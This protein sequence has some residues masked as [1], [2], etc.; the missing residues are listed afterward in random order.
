MY[1]AQTVIVGGFGR[2]RAAIDKIE[3]LHPRH[4]VC[5]HQNNQLDDD[6][7][8]TIAET[9]QY[10]DDAE[11]LLQTHETALDLFNAKLER[12]PN[13][14][15]GT[16]LWAGVQTLYGGRE[17]PEENIRRIIVRSWLCRRAGPSARRA[18]A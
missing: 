14:L 15:G 12:Y 13:H 5:G 7:R 18:Q 6:A 16:L 2:W 1:L 11:E 10:L 17:H 3:A 9:R 4:I 8:R